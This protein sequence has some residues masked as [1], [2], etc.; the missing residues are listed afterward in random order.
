MPYL[1]TVASSNLVMAMTSREY[2]STKQASERYGL[3]VS[4]L[5]KLRVFGTGPHF[6]KVGRRCL[7]ER[8]AF[9]EWLKQHSRTSTSD[10]GDAA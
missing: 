9:E 8:N 2:L 10:S 5:T 3:S 6:L 1:Q 4:W 7:Y